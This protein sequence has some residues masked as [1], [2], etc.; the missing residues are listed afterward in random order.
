MAIDISGWV[1]RDRANHVFDLNGSVGANGDGL[2]TL[3]AGRLPLTNSGDRIELL[4][5]DGRLVHVVNYAASDVVEGV[6]VV[7][8]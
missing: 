4:D 2:I 1:L 3:P 6:E 7:F 5:D 8:P